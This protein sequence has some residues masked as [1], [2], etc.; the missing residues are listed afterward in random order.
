[1]AS[2]FVVD[3]HDLFDQ[4]ISSLFEYD[5]MWMHVIGHLVLVVMPV[6]MLFILLRWLFV[7]FRWLSQTKSKVGRKRTGEKSA[8]RLP[9]SLMG[10]VFLYSGKSQCFL[11]ILALS[12]LPLTYLQLEIPKG[13]I[14]GAISPESLTA[15]G[16]F[17]EHI[18]ESNDYLLILCAMYLAALVASAYMK[19]SLNISMGKTSERLLRL[20]RLLVVKKRTNISEDERQAT[21]IPVVTQ[22]VE[23]ICNFAGDAFIVPLLHG[24]TV[25]TILSFMMMQNVMLGA[26]AITMLPIQLIVIPRIQSRINSHVQRRI[27]VIREVSSA[28]HETLTGRTRT[29]VRAQIRE[30]QLIRHRIFEN[31]Y[32]MKSLNNFIMN[33]TPFFLYT[34]GGFMVLEGHLS[35]GSLVASLASYKDLAP[36]IKELFNYYQR[37]HDARLRYTEVLEFVI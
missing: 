28:L 8:F 4:S 22:E 32:L 18:I 13:I 10:F 16:W 20:I 14:N 2:S 19:Y 34:I 17:P 12:I 25:I 15:D 21:L 31:K 37:I 11:A 27:G 29:S 3:L 1:M 24:G 36:A 9:S 23:P 30:L 26:A 6:A 5:N 33:L 7:F 35:L